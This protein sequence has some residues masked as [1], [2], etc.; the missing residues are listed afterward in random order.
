MIGQSVVDY[1]GDY[2]IDFAAAIYDTADRIR[3]QNMAIR[4]YKRRH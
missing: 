3:A 1:N 4:P 2:G